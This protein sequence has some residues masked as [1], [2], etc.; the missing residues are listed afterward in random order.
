[1]WAR[2]DGEHDA[3][4]Y[5]AEV[6]R[7]FAPSLDPGDEAV[8]LPRDEAEHLTRVLRLGVGDIV[9]VFDGR[10]HEFSARVVRAERREARVQI[11][12]RLDPAIEPA[13]AV[14]LAQAVLKGEHMDDIVRDAVMLGVAAV[15]P[16]V[17]TRAET[18]VAALAR[19]ARPERWRRVALA[20]IKQSGRAVL[21][22]IRG[23]LTLESFLDEPPAA[24]TLMFVEPG[25]GGAAEPISALRNQP[26]PADAAIL[27][28]P[29]GGWVA[30]ECQAARAHGARLVTLGGRT[31]RSD[32]APVAAIS[33]LQFLWGDL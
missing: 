19:G 15:Q 27:I 12:S 14:T 28:G 9:S 23:P 13:V 16:L 5:N 1:M 6:H 25:A 26:V 18:T 21:P 2:T 3:R 10:G 20:S 30:P 29:E 22:E 24:L 8:T 33:V 17:T 11:V 7:F 4:P 31:L 32:V